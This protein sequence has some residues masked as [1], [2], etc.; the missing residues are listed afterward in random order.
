MCDPVDSGQHW[1]ALGILTYL[2]QPGLAEG[3]V[4]HSQIPGDCISLPDAIVWPGHQVVV[5]QNQVCT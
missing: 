5:F 4:I 3:N 2:G 1:S